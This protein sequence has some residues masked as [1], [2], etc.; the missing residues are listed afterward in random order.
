MGVKA[1]FGGRGLY[2]D[3]PS[4][5][6][7]DYVWALVDELRAVSPEWIWPDVD[8][9]TLPRPPAIE[10]DP[11]PPP[12]KYRRL[13]EWFMAQTADPLVVEHSQA[14]ALVDGGLPEGRLPGCFARTLITN[15]PR[16][17]F[18]RTWVNA[19]Y[20]VT[21]NSGSS[22]VFV[23]GYKRVPT[24]AEVVRHRLVALHHVTKCATERHDAGHLNPPTSVYL[25]HLPDQGLYK[26]G[27]GV[28]AAD[29]IS[30]QRTGRR[31]DVV[32][33]L[34]ARFKRCAWA[35]ES[36]VLNLTE[37]WRVIDDRWRSGG[38][39]ECWSDDGPVPDLREVADRLNPTLVR[40][41]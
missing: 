33:V 31:I 39:L 26:V 13:H 8:F 32:Q 16:K 40:D 35:V 15:N 18:A 14:D 4:P 12:R 9:K 3:D 25:V 17:A 20:L 5:E 36:I 34:D 29:R 30:R 10:A 1:D 7:V 22:A 28:D 24:R 37:P 21:G 38:P 23:R 6:W 27:V 2:I 11:I 19:G 41:A